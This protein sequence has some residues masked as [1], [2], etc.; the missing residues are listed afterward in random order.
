MSIVGGKK[1]LTCKS[2]QIHNFSI[3]FRK[4]DNN[5]VS[6]ASFRGCLIG[7]LAGDCFG[8]IYDGKVNFSNEN[9]AQ[10]FRTVVGKFLKDF[11]NGTFAEGYLFEWI[12]FSAF[13]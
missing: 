11:P 7:A 8:K 9:E 5:D 4:L 13:L 12:I 2:L 3:T 10:I 6:L 1:Q